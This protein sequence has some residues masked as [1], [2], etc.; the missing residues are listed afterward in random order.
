M[1]IHTWRERAAQQR[2]RSAS[3]PGMPGNQIDFSGAIG[4]LP[5]EDLVLEVRAAFPAQELR[6]EESTA[7]TYWEGAIDVRG[8]RRGRPVT[9]RGYLEMTGYTGQEMSD[10]LR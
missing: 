8:T 9:G 4:L 10:L 5:G 1:D 3:F 7:V 6:T 2:A